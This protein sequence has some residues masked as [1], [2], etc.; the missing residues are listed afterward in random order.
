MWNGSRAVLRKRFT[1]DSQG[2]ADGALFCPVDAAD[3]LETV[4]WDLRRRRSRTRTAGVLF[5]Q[6]N[7][8]IPADWSQLATNVVVSKY[9]YGEIGTPERETASG[10]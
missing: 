3:P 1:N 9:F 7:C 4:E 8:E 10:S 6:P 5:E 2:A